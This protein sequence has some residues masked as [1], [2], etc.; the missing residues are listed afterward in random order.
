MKLKED[1]P[2]V[3]PESPLVDS[4]K[5]TTNGLLKLFSDD[6]RIGRLRYMAYMF[7]IFV[8]GL[9]AIGL[10]FL[11]TVGT[12]L[13]WLPA[14]VMAIFMFNFTI[15]RCHDFN[16]SGIAATLALLFIPILVPVL[17]LIPG[18]KK[19]NKYGNQPAPNTLGV[20]IGVTLFILFLASVMLLIAAFLF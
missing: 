8:L 7:G 9:V 19:E 16:S 20:Y 6:G 12:Y 2:F 17:F 1:N 15:K 3:T 4:S 11:P 13:K 14:I 18:T 10:S 5:N